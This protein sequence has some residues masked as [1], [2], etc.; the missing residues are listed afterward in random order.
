M[1]KDYL[2][3]LSRAAQ[4]RLG[5]KEAEEV[6]ADYREMVGNPPRSEKD[7]VREL[8]KPL[9]AVKPLT[10]RKN[11]W[12][13]LGVFAVLAVCLAV[14]GLS[15]PWSAWKEPLYPLF[16]GRHCLA[17]IPALLG[18]LGALIWFRWTGKKAAQLPR[19]VP[20]LLAVLLG[21]L[22]LV[23]TASWAWMHDP[24]GFSK[25]WGGMLIYRVGDILLDPPVTASRSVYILNNSLAWVG[26]RGMTAIGIFALVK[27]RTEDR[28]WCA[29]Y[30]LAMAAML[31]SLEALALLSSMS[32][33]DEPTWE[34]F[35][36]HR[37]NIYAALAAAGLVGTG[38][39]LC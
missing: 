37:F 7:L 25:M 32:I 17:R 21:G 23:L 3:R 28:R 33:P 26:G 29:V 9:D 22:A 34:N 27:A 13:W 20:V 16:G 8:G 2:S 5:A 19:A 10:E 14:P 30:I 24:M 1:K 36:S 6:I 15:A 4:W 11:Y 12:V 31:V 39:A 35:F 18:V 38:A